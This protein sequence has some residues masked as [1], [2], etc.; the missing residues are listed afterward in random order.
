MSTKQQIYGFDGYQALQ[1]TED[2]LR[3]T[4]N[5][6]NFVYY[7]YYVSIFPCGNI[8]VNLDS[9]GKLIIDEYKELLD[10]AKKVYLHPICTIPR[11]LVTEKYKKCLNPWE[12]DVAIIPRELPLSEFY[13][14]AVFVNEESK[15]FLYII[16]KDY[17]LCEKLKN[18]ELNKFTLQEMRINNCEVLGLPWGLKD[19]VSPS[20]IDASKFVYFGN[21]LTV[22]NKYNYIFDFITG[23]FPTSKIV[24]EDTLLK[25][26][27]SEDNQITLESLVSIK[28]MLCSSDEA[29]VTAALK[30]LAAMDYTHYANSINYIFT[31]VGF[32]FRWNKGMNSTAVKYMIKSLYPEYSTHRIRSKYNDSIYEEDYNL[33]KQLTEHFHDTSILNYVPFVSISGTECMPYLKS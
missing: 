15:I 7:N 26:L 29:I 32:R 8:D 27:S 4:S 1:M 22:P 25:S 24:Y 5:V 11:A 19:H 18:T 10:S 9:D 23:Q 21:A 12:A 33:F 31:E 30:S 13:Q 14:M 2:A 28:E 17:N 6:N 3:N 20:D 16:C